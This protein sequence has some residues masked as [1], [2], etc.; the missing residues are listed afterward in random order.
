MRAIIIGAGRGSRLMP[1]TADSPKCFAEVGGKRILDWILEALFAGGVEEIVFVGG[2]QI[3]RIQD[4]YP[5]FTFVH[6]ANWQNN[7][8]MA[9]L[10]Y[11]RAYMDE[12]FITS[13]ADILYTP[14]AIKRLMRSQADIT[15]LVDTL[16]AERYKSR[17]E[18]PMS[19]GEKMTA[20]NGLVTR[21]HRDIEPP[22]AYGEFTGVAKFSVMGA[23]QLVRHYDRLAPAFTGRPFREAAVFEKAYLIHLLQDMI[24]AGI[25]MAHVDTPGGYWEIDTQQDFSLARAGWLND[26]SH[27]AGSD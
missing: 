25:H 12:P 16:W 22:A 8:I 2:Y 24:E 23:A 14:A 19:D 4:E 27:H 11:A 6:N 9:S 26:V 1:T 7:N 13:Y 3:D 17:S 10:M 20:S 15:M 5:R 21:V 18:H